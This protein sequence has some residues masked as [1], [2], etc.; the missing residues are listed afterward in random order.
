MDIFILI[1]LAVKIHNRAK[2]HQEKPWFWVF[3]L[4]SLFICSELLIGII[5]LK[6]FGLEKIIYAVIPALGLASLSA[7]Y[8]FQQLRKTI[9][10]KEN[11]LENENQESKRPNL[12]HFR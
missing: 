1:Y 10:H 12:D 4:V 2:K 6:Y 11:E 7:Y 9:A 3:R 5:V 8:V